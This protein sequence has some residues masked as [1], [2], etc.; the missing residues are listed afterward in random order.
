MIE[1]VHQYNLGNEKV[2]EKLIMEEDVNVIHM[3]FNKGEGLPE[4]F[5]NAYV[6]MIVMRGTLSIQLDDQDNHKYQKG[7][8]L[9]IPFKTKMNV[10][11]QDDETLELMV[12]KV[13][14]E[15]MK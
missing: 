4:H 14:T 13:F 7:T 6:Q 2:V 9:Q 3:I 8:I 11:N 12:V 15:Q 1:K 10:R 5:A